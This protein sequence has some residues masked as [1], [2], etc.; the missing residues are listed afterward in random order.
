MR[1]TSPL[2]KR[3]GVC[4]KPGVVNLVKEDSEENGGLIG[5]FWLEQRVNLD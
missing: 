4:A 2:R 1:N 3:G 5:R